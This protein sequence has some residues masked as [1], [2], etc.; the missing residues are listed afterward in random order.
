[1]WC[2][3]SCSVPVCPWG[4]KLSR[5]RAD[6]EQKRR[7][8]LFRCKRHWTRLPWV[9][10]AS[11]ALCHYQRIKTVFIP[12]K[13]CF[14]FYIQVTY[15]VMPFRVCEKTKHKQLSLPFH[16]NLSHFH[17]LQSF[18]LFIFMRKFCALKK[19]LVEIIR[20]ISLKLSVLFPEFIKNS[21]GPAQSLRNH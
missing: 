21:Q 17:L 20:C 11:S 6:A 7:P 8:F 2:S 9:A 18:G 4:S 19:K 5:Q 14:R 15:K 12:R 3:A 16:L 10:D 1:M 13:H